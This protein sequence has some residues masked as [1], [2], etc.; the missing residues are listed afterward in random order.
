MDEELNERFIPIGK[1]AEINHVSI[2]TL[3]HYDKL[4]LLKPKYLNVQTGYCYYDIQQNARLDMIAYMKELGM[5]LSEIAHV[6]EKGDLGEI[7]GVLAEKN[8]QF[9]QEMAE[10]KMRHDAVERAIRSIERYRKAPS[11]GVPSLEFIERRYT[12]GV[13]CQNNFYET[14]DISAYERCVAVLHQALLKADIPNIHSYNEGT[15]ILKE[16][17]I[18]G[19]F[20]AKDAFAFLDHNLSTKLNDV[21]IVESGMFACIY[22][23]KYEDEVPFATRLLEF[24]Q[25]QGYR[26]SGNY[27]CEILTGFNVFDTEERSM[28]LRLQV[29]VAFD[30]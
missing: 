20:V 21:S 13:P 18:R 28:Y 9:H 19:N 8:E 11:T 29:P 12:W 14:D 5:S 3:R 22:A 7:E 1:M 2:A 25:N 23:D 27:I 16:D 17:F 10:L 30:K 6:F 15:S 24:C 4:G 26:I